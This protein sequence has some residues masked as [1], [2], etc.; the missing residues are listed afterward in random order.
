MVQEH[1]LP[2]VL[3]SG[4]ESIANKC[5]AMLHKWSVFLGDSTCLPEHLKS[6]FSFCGAELGIGHFHVENFMSSMATT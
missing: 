6:F 3:G 5:A 2:V 1:D 4:A